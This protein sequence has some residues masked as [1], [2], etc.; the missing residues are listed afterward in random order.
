MKDRS[1]S[2][3][4]HIYLYFI[5]SLF[6]YANNCG[7]VPVICIAISINEIHWNCGK[8]SQS[9]TWAVNAVIEFSHLIK[10]V[11]IHEIV[12]ITAGGAAEFN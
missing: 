2:N 11:Q 3:F 8:S 7:Y 6:I 1:N 5:N 9:T 4:I 12:L 10:L